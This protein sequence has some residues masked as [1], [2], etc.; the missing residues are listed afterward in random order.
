[1][2]QTA[3]IQ[4]LCMKMY[5]LM[6]RMY[7]VTQAEIGLRN[8]SRKSSKLKFQIKRYYLF[9]VC[10]L[11]CIHNTN[12]V[13]RSFIKG[14]YI[15]CIRYTFP[16]RWRNIGGRPSRCFAVPCLP[17]HIQ[18]TAHLHMR[19]P[20][21]DVLQVQDLGNESKGGSGCHLLPSLPGKVD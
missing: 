15:R 19:E 2:N 7:G 21:W 12:F 9:F 8:S 10:L 14:P 16:G 6:Q 4:V 18:T 17:R 5:F 1:M 3:F 13:K 20:A 11:H